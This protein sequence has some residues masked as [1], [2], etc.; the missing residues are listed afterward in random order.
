MEWGN[1]EMAEINIEK[2]QEIN[3]DKILEVHA[4][5]EYSILQI[6]LN[7]AAT[8]LVSGLILSVT[9]FITH[10]IALKQ[11]EKLKV[12]A[13]KE[14]VSTADTFKPI[15]GKTE[16]YAA[17][18]NGQT[19]AY[20]VPS[21]SKGYG[22]PIKMLVAVTSKGQV[23]DFRITSHNETPGLGD[24]AKDIK[25][26]SGLQDKTSDALTVVKDPTNTKNVQAM[27][28]ATITSKAVTKG[29]KEA[30]DE[31]VSFTGGK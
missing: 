10:P 16:W 12:M 25:F 6:A 15:E 17:E 2:M 21:E 7:L 28:G 13:M 19:I 18:K 29:V 30:V 20:V 5:K 26:R 4:E 1:S 11:S 14:L 24:K 9:Y 8:C 3:T 27:T 23:I 22:G 31:V